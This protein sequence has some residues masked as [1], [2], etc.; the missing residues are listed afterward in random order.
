MLKIY[1]IKP[2]ISQYLIIKIAQLNMNNKCILSK[3]L[4]FF[5]FQILISEKA[6]SQDLETGKQLFQMYCNACHNHGNNLIIPEKNL[7]KKTLQT[8]G[9]FDLDAIIYQINNGKNG[10]PAFGDRLT[11]LQIQKISAFIMNE[12]FK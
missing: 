8:N 5:C 12:E 11:E 1:L 10:M 4:F 2:F 7:Y 9:I 6:F 3:S